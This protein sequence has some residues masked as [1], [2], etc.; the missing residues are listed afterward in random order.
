M[1]LLFDTFDDFVVFPSPYQKRKKK[2]KMGVAQNIVGMEEGTLEVAMGM[3]CF[4]L[5]WLLVGEE[6]FRSQ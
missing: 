6:S 4:H 2:L 1:L 3:L 5:L